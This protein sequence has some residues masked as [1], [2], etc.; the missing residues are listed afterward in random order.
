MKSD[1]SFGYFPVNPTAIA[2]GFYLTG[3]GVERIAPRAGYPLPDHPEMYQFSW[4][5]GRV[6]PEYQW[7]FLSAGHGEFE[8]HETGV[9][10]VQAGSALM[11]LP[12]V[13]HRYRPKSN[14]GWTVYWLSFNGQVPHFWQQAGLLTS[15]SAVYSQKSNPLLAGALEQIVQSAVKSPQDPGSASLSSLA[16]IAG[17]LAAS[18]REG[19]SDGP[20]DRP[21]RPAKSADPVLQ[22]A[23]EMIW[24]HS[25]RDLSVKAIARQLGVSTRTIER[26]FRKALGRTVLEELTACR[27]ARAQLM[28][29]NT[30]LPVKRIAY[31]AGFSSPTHMAVVFRRELGQ[32][33]RQLRRGEAPS[34]SAADINQ[35]HV[36]Q[37]KN[38]MRG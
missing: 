34:W 35:E 2:T 37:A 32:T 27:V 20:N 25:H 36:K 38:S 5:T 29:R 26:G 9:V 12:D 10:Q 30:R 33:P 16:L 7:V 3:A 21:P 18:P 28:L 14:T 24:N 15:A 11:I 22:G 13:W 6:L 8:S 31:A 19:R 17:M 23:M 1:T 4:K